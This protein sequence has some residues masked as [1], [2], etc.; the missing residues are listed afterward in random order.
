MNQKAVVIEV[1]EV[2][3]KIFRHYQ[4]LRPKS[5]IARLLKDSLVLTTEAKDVTVDFL[6]PAQTWASFN[7]GAS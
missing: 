5:Q 3:L 2:P 4:Q 7:T 1:N 6:Y